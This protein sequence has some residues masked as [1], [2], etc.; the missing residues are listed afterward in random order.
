MAN[1]GERRMVFDIRGRRKHVVKFVYA[2]LALLM[3]ASLFL[4]VG[5]V[6]INSLL[7]GGGGT[8]NGAG[9]FEEQAEGIERRLKKDPGA[10][11][12]WLGLTRRRIG[13]ANSLAEVDP[14]T[15][16]PHQTVESR[17]QL[18]KA[19]DAWSSYLKHAGNEPNAGAAQL[20]SGALFTLASTASTTAEAEANLR[21]AEEAQEIVAAARPSVG[22]VSTLAVYKYYTFDYASAEKLERQALALANSKAEKDAVKRQLGEVHKRAKE[23]QKQAKAA[24]KASKGSGKEALQNPLGGLGG[25]P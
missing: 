2:V 6:N 16:E 5:P 11:E 22:A 15:G 23:F 4:V 21:E 8:S 13:A 1:S 25:A 3:G 19:S 20:A 9:V 14:T 12:L 18:L 17:E 10:A 24:E 7:G